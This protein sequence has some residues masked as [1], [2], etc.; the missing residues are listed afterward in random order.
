[1]CCQEAQAIMYG[2][3]GH[4][5]ASKQQQMHWACCWGSST[6]SILM[7]CVSCCSF[8]LHERRFPG[9]ASSHLGPAGSEA[10]LFVFG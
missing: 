9:C 1:M 4:K 2:R 7:S 3:R 10:L 8:V 6:S 5:Q